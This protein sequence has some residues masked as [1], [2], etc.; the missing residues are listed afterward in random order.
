MV[1]Q[2]QSTLDWVDWWIQFSNTVW[3]KF[4]FIIYLMRPNKKVFD[5]C[6]IE[7]NGILSGQDIVRFGAAIEEHVKGR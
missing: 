6:Q 2:I 3:K 4:L 1:G 5:L 7:K